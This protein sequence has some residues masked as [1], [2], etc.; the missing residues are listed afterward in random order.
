MSD[1]E[2]IDDRNM[3]V[4]PVSNRIE[5]AVVYAH[6]VDR[7][8]IG[9]MFADL[10][11]LPQL[12]LTGV[13]VLILPLIVAFAV[14]P[15]QGTLV[16]AAIFTILGVV[17]VASSIFAGKATI[18]FEHK[19]MRFPYICWK[20]LKAD[21]YKCWSELYDLQ[22]V[23]DGLPSFEPEEIEFRFT[24][25][26]IASLRLDGLSRSDLERLLLIVNVYRPDIRITPSLETANFGGFNLGSDNVISF[27]NIWYQELDTRFG[28][29]AFLPLECGDLIQDGNLRV[30][31]Q[32]AFGGLS[33][34]YL[35]ENENG[36]AILKEALL[37]ESAS[38]ES[39]EKAI[40]LFQRE[41]RMLSKIDHPRIARVYDYFV[42][43][44]RHYLLLEHIDGKN[45]CVFLK[46][47]GPPSE[48]TVLMWAEE[49]AAIL[50]YLHG[51]EPPIVHRDLTPGNLIVRSDGE[52]ALIDFGAAN[53]F[54]GTATGTVIG[55]SAYIPLEQFRGRATL[56]SDIYAFG[57][58]IYFLLTGRDPEPFTSNDVREYNQTV[59]DELRRLVLECM[60]LE[61]H[62][63]LLS[64]AQLRQ[65]IRDLRFG[66]PRRDLEYGDRERTA[67][68]LEGNP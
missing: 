24:D 18:S 21:K 8:L 66:L 67:V 50:E 19:G 14:W 17:W 47:F 33:A 63:R 4:S 20:A 13:C 53:E 62:D 68:S 51:L 3:P 36:V 56:A 58:T 37:P 31:G 46:E 25:L 34:V 1:T 55:K 52:I 49:I 5:H 2:A 11:E 42:E 60:A 39:R 27:T 43:Q 54:V 9:S 12:G 48:S 15:L 44:S 10:A 64:A 40:E 65:R 28:S 16:V 38:A 59:S 45:L 61:P 7:S 6:H 22:F 35:V 30:L 32:K 26:S 29:T 57:G 41:A 23:A